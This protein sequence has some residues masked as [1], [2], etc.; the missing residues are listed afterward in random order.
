MLTFA[1]SPDYEDPDDERHRQ[2]M[3]EVTIQASDGGA[4]RPL[5][6]AVT[7]EVTNVEEPGTVT[8]DTLQPQVDVP[9]TATL[10][11]PDVGQ[12]ENTVTW[13]WYRGSSAIANAT[14]GAN[15]LKH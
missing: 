3:Y 7:I 13:Q 12:E 14:N 2:Y 11:D 1:S 8:L 4:T 10:T 15:T 6:K 9:I 5:L